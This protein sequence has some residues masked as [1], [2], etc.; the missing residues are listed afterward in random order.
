[1]GRPDLAASCDLGASE[2]SRWRLLLLVEVCLCAKASA[3]NVEPIGLLPE[4][5]PVV[6]E[7][8]EEGTRTAAVFCHNTLCGKASAAVGSSLSE[9]SSLILMFASSMSS[10]AYVPMETV[11]AT[12]LNDASVI[13]GSSLTGTLRMSSQ[14]PSSDCSLSGE[15][16]HPVAISELMEYVWLHAWC[17]P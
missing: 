16:S 12:T 14:K 10:L 17:K 6:A 2:G 5:P 3:G 9:L 1:M 13:S 15:L 8:S 7:G 11:G 4:D